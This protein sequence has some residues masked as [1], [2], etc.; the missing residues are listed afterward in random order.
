MTKYRIIY[1]P[2]RS[3]AYPYY[4][5]YWSKQCLNWQDYTSIQCNGSRYVAMQEIPRSFETKQ[6]ALNYIN[7][8]RKEDKAKESSAEV[9]WGDEDESR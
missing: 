6:E 8:K 9:V 4:P 5:Q 3:C 1:A 7:E 2:Q